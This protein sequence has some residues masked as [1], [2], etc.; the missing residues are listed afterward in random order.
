MESSKRL[1]SISKTGLKFESDLSDFTSGEGSK[2]SGRA[3]D[4]KKSERQSQASQ[5]NGISFVCNL[6][7]SDID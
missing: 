5:E 1:R 7:L 2:D 3:E 4:R 6:D